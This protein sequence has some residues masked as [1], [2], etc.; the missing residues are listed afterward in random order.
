MPCN[1]P[2][3]RLLYFEASAGANSARI[4]LNQS[5]S[6]SSA[7]SVESPVAISF[8]PYRDA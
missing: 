3:K 6:S 4:W 7:T 1:G 8:A 5:A 2:N